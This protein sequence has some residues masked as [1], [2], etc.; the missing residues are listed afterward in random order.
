MCCDDDVVAISGHLNARIGLDED[1]IVNIDD[2]SNRLSI[3]NVRNNL[4]DSKCCVC[5][6]RFD[7]SKDN[8][9]GIFQ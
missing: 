6:G 8:Y 7:S 4:K 1:Y 5:N 2:V 3:D 9:T